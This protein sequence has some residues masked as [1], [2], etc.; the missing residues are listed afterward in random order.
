MPSPRRVQSRPVCEAWTTR[1]PLRAEGHARAVETLRGHGPR[2][3][4]EGPGRV[5]REAAHGAVLPEAGRDGAECRDN[6]KYRLAGRLVPPGPRGL[7]L[8]AGEC[9]ETVLRGHLWTVRSV[10]V[11]MRSVAPCDF[12]S[13]MA[14]TRECGHA[15]HED[16]DAAWIQQAPAGAVPT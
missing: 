4:I 10:H 1:T 9:R 8:F 3:R 13:P 6:F 16:D 15:L 7:I 2:L 5:D 14:S 12:S 11:L